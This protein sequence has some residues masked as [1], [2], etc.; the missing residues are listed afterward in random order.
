MMSDRPS[1]L[2]I[3]VENQVR[4]LDAKLLLACLAAQRGYRVLFGSRA[5]CHFAAAAVPRGVYLAKSMRGLSGG[6]FGILRLLGHAI[7]SWEEEA[8]VH[9]PPETYFGLRLSP[10]TLGLV[11]HVF[12]WG[13]ENVDLLRQYPQ[14]PENLPIHVTGN[15]RGDLLRPELRPFFDD[16]VARLRREHGDFL[17]INTNFSDVNP[18]IP[19]VGLFLPAGRAGEK[20]KFGQAGKGMS[21]AFAEGLR[22]HKRK[23][24]AAF[25]EV[26]PALA[27]AFPDLGIVLRPHPAE[28][29]QIYQQLARRCPKVKVLNQGNVV[30]WLLAA[31]A[32]LHNGCTTGLEAY[33]LGVP[34][35]S[36]L[37]DFDEHY[38][39]DFQGL[40][41]KLSH[42]SFHLEE[43]TALLRRILAGELGAA[44]GGERQR[45]ADYYLA[46]QDGPLA[47]ER[48]LDVLDAAG[49]AD[50]PPPAAS[51][52]AFAQGWL[53]NN[54]KAGLTRLNMRRPGPNRQG[55][56]DHRFPELAVADLE[57]RVAKFGKLLNRFDDI[58]IRSRSRHLFWIDQ[59]AAG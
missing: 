22:D 6:M 24:L 45:L 3:P 31:R 35:V 23:V 21:L 9:P 40:P 34:A 19:A 1:T 15:P 8:L 52:R 51:A 47:C 38:D 46:A 42:E 4:E 41:T 14:L 13:Q 37:P 44:S 5:Y 36:H 28:R 26:V 57:G 30:P 56:H 12:A 50:R 27:R 53:L 54:L 17:L 7:V 10:K 32:L 11:S 49:Y 39:Y 55:Y 59:G 58:R 43:L 2:L 29:H 20:P 48:I 25:L 16:E 33:L 18:F